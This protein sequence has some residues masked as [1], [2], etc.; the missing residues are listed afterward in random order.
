MARAV[1][2]KDKK[3]TREDLAISLRAS[4]EKEFGA[5]NVSGWD[6]FYGSLCG[7]PL[8][9]NLPLQ[10]ILGVDIL[11][12]GRCISVVGSWGSSKSS[13]CWYFASLFI[14]YSG[15]CQFIDT[16]FKNN[17]D[18]IRGI[19]ENTVY[20]LPPG[21]FQRNKARDIETMMAYCL[22]ITEN[23]TKAGGM[24]LGFPV[25]LL[26]DSLGNPASQREKDNE[27]EGKSNG[28]GD[29][30]NAAEIQKK[31]KMFVPDIES[32]PLLCLFINHQKVK[33]TPEA[34]KGKPSYGPPETSEVGGAHKDFA[35]TWLIQLEKGLKE[36][37][38]VDG[39]IPYFNIITK[40]SSLGKEALRP[41]QVPYRSTLIAP[42]S[43]K[44]AKE[45]GAE[46]REVIWF[47]WDHALALLLT[48]DKALNQSKLADVMHIERTSAT[49][50]F[51]TSKTLGLTKVLGHEIGAAIHA[52]PE[53]VRNLQD[54]VLHIRRKEKFGKLMDG[55][56]KPARVLTADDAPD[57][58]EAGE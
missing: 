54:H 38:L 6:D 58:D 34:S 1:K 52:D 40:K 12:M 51:F 23:I 16:E 5:E 9:D 48:N 18:Q 31:M 20:P 53:L 39:K 21:W 24:D 22:W 25:L 29:M 56:V 19:L 17:P 49:G 55:Y 50:K 11:P 3:I 2:D 46:P 47:D 44:D 30:K 57:E 27:K 42:T 32:L 15:I 8:D 37:S 13:L 36:R 45:F 41:I 43:D 10:H 14:K 26:V 28:Y 4:C 35:Y 7:V 33:H